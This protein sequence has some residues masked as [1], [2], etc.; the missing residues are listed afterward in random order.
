[1]CDAIS[2]ISLGLSITSAA[3]TAYQQSANQRSQVRYQSG[4]TRATQLNAARAA[5]S[6][7]IATA[8]RIV[9]Q[10]Q[11]A[12][13]EAFEAAREAD[14][15]QGEL[16]AGAER[17]GL[18]GSVGDLRSSIAVQ[19]A[20]DLAIRSRNADWQE[21][22]IMRSLENINAQHQSRLNA[23]MPTPVP[24]VDYLG[25]LGGLAQDALGAYGGYQV[26]QERRRNRNGG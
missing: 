6:D 4:L 7:Y 1:M 13:Q 9:Q 22:Q 26:R 11:S 17:A 21:Q 18:G 24:G 3:G 8:E 15:A 23:A 16:L 14:R 12:A 20:N 25:I 5:N 10:R 2:L 19:A